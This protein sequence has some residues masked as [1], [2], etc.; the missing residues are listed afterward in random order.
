[1]IITLILFSSVLSLVHYLGL[2]N[3]LYDGIKLP[4]P[5]YLGLTGLLIVIRIFVWIYRWVPVIKGFIRSV[6]RMLGRVNSLPNGSSVAPTIPRKWDGQGKRK[7]STSAASGTAS[8]KPQSRNPKFSKQVMDRFFKV[9]AKKGS[10]VSLIKNRVRPDLGQ[11][12]SK[13]GFRM[14]GIVFTM[15]GSYRSRLR[16]LNAFWVHLDHMRSHHGTAY[17]VKYLKVSQLA[18]QKAIAGTPVSSLTALEPSLFFRSVSGNGLP[19]IIP[20]RDRRLMIR[21]HAP[22][23]IRWWLTLFSVYRVIHLPVTL[24]LGTITDPLSVPI[25]QVNHVADEISKLIPQSMVNLDLMRNAELLFLETASSTSKVSWLG[26]IADTKSLVSAGL[27]LPLRNLMNLMGNFQLSR[28][29]TYITQQVHAPDNHNKFA[30][31]GDTWALLGL[32]TG[33]VGKLSVK[34]EAAGK[35]RVFAMVD[36]WTQS[37]LKPL[38]NMLFDLLKRLPNDGTFNQ[39]AS[40][41]R[42][43]EKCTITGKSFGYD[44]SAATDRLP[45][46]LQVGLINTWLPGLGELWKEVLVTRAYWFEVPKSIKTW[47]G[48][49]LMALNYAVGQP[50]GALSSW[51]MLAICHHALAQLAS[52]RVAL[53]NRQRLGPFWKKIYLSNGTYYWWYVGYEVLGDDIV[54]FEQHVAS[55]Y[56]VIMETIGVPINL[57]KSV[58]AVNP[59]FEFAKVTGHY[60]HHVAALS[61]AMLM[62]QPTLM[63]RAQI[64]YALIAKGIIQS[65]PIKVLNVLARQSRHTVGSPNAF[66]LALATMFAKKGRI[67][68]SDL[69]VAVLQKHLGFLNVYSTLLN[70]V[71]LTILQ[72]GIAML[73]RTSDPVT[74]PNP[75]IKRRGWKTDEFAMKQT[76][77]TVLQAFINGGATIEGNTVLSLNPQKDA[78]KL[79][80]DILTSPSLSLSLEGDRLLQLEAKGCFSWRPK[81][82]ELLAPWESFVFHLF[83]ILSTSI[84]DKL[85]MIQSKLAMVSD[86]HG[87]SINE[88]LE[89]IDEIQRYREICDLLTR[90]KDKL[91]KKTQPDRNLIDSPLKALELLVDMDDPFGADFVTTPSLYWG[92]IAYEYMGALERLE[93]L[94]ISDLVPIGHPDPRAFYLSNFRPIGDSVT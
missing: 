13:L 3:L 33:K 36:V 61:W 69:A 22:S 77:I 25:S 88:L 48:D 5:Y 83:I 64:G 15:K 6:N 75:L 79:A 4:L 57:S 50:M 74:L 52:R 51:A 89:Y 45:I 40:V 44:L 92:A 43:M 60:G 41:M 94:P 81:S 84:Y 14:F 47:T 49:K 20:L 19:K 2:E 90:A 91:A 54:F 87:L 16:Q 56:L 71:N 66:F 58:V 1:M 70:T 26:F 65:A 63:G 76:L 73:T 86:W 32:D 7:Y 17:V 68:F 59:T 30:V 27:F 42:C 78:F 82:L 67:S 37:A 21:N 29:F 28:I 53:R 62:A 85:I 55:E 10:L 72:Q 93:N 46:I 39:H 8:R 18:I 9:I 23:V 38:H 24:K 80:K 34:E 11:L 35:A 31:T 12:F